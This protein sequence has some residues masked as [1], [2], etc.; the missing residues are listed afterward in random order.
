MTIPDPFPR[1]MSRPAVAA[2]P[3]SGPAAGGAGAH[4]AAAAP[5]SWRWRRTALLLA[6]AP[7]ALAALAAFPPAWVAAPLAAAVLVAGIA[8]E[9]THIGLFFVPALAAMAVAA[10]LL[11]REGT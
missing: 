7:A 1:R 3:V 10:V 4:A 11:W 5:A 9:I 2:T 8:G 6:V